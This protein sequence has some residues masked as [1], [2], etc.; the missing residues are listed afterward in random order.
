M[1]TNTFEISGK[2]WKVETKL[3]T[4]A[5]AEAMLSYL[6]D[7]QRRLRVGHASALIAHMETGRFEGIDT[8]KIDCDG[9]VIDGQHRLFAIAQSGIP[10]QM[11]IV[12]NVPNHIKQYLDQGAKRSEGDRLKMQYGLNPSTGVKT[13]LKLLRT[14]LCRTNYDI[15]IYKE[16]ITLMYK[17]LVLHTD[18]LKLLSQLDSKKKRGN[19]WLNGPQLAAAIAV[20]YRYDLSVERAG[21]LWRWAHLA[22]HGTSTGA[23]TTS[24]EEHNGRKFF[25]AI[26]SKRHGLGGR[27][28]MQNYKVAIH[29]AE[30]HL[31]GK[32]AQFKPKEK[33][34]WTFPGC[35][36]TNGDN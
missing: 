7:D 33:H 13:A 25:E 18:S 15:N 27:E 36:I 1:N 20:L 28:V 5:L 29:V 2:T 6:H 35:P 17:D 4:P 12:S 11:I 14:D 9:N 22:S 31:L 23:G 34:T 32:Q 30:Q 24:L 10:Q 16:D 8:V 3:I 26:R 21:A 19:K